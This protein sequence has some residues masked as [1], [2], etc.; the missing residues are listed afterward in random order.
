V[1]L[2]YAVHSHTHDPQTGTSA[3]ELDKARAAYRSFTGRA[4]VAYR[5]PIGRI[6]RAGLGRLMDN[7]YSYD[8]SVYTSIRP[9]E[10][11]Y[12][13]L[14]LPNVPFWITRAGEKALLEF[15][16]TAI[17]TVRVVYALSYAKMLGW[18][19]YSML[20]KIFGLPEVALLLV[21]PYNFYTRANESGLHGFERWALTRNDE[22]SF[23]YFEKMV[24]ALSQRGYQ[25]LF[26][27]EMYERL[28][29]SADLKK[30]KWEAWK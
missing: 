29:D 25:F 27:S 23:E 30:L 28:K 9:G 3:E 21:H 12:F 16:F 6:D 20:L 15:P 2:E 1:P 13:K 24:A 14:H 5:A 10:Y 17:S 7:G 4:P 22:Q 18:P 8:S 11:G 19:L 26:V